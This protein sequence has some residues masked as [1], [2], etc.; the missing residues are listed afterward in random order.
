M[1]LTLTP[2]RTALVVIDLRRGIAGAP[3][4]PHPAGDVVAHAAAVAV[5]LVGLRDRPRRGGRTG[6][7]GPPMACR[8]HHRSVERR[9]LG[10]PVLHGG[11]LVLPERAPEG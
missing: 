7:R 3:T 10:P 9:R 5:A 1:D 11:L 8:F 4:A 6:R 2:S